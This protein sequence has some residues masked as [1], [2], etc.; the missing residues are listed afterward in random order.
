MIFI[1]SVLGGPEL[2]GS[3]VDQQISELM[4]V[5]AEL[6]G[7]FVLGS[8]PAVNV[9]FL[10]PGSRVEPDFDGLLDGTFSAAQQLLTVEV[11]VPEE[12][13]ESET[14]TPFLVQSLQGANAV[15]FHYF[16]ELGVNFPLR[17]AEQLVQEI[18]DSM[19]QR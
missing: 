9:V 1:G 4:D 6:R 8:C 3:P 13:L 16:D 14:L 5:A 7:P 17:E 2:Q 19:R 12:E 15:A 18:G 10:V 11:A